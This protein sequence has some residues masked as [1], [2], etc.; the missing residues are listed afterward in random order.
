MNFKKVNDQVRRFVIE[1]GLCKPKGPFDRG[2]NETRLSEQCCYMTSKS[3]LKI[4]RSRLC[5]F[6]YS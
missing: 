1:N 4:E 6:I 5:Y 2:S 3:G